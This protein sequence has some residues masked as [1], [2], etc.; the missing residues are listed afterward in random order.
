MIASSGEPRLLD[1]QTLQRALLF[2]AASWGEGQP[3]FPFQ[4]TT[5]VAEYVRDNLCWSVRESSSLLSNLLRLNF[6]GLCL[7]FD[8]IVAM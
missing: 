1:L 8:H 2:R 4:N 7:E 3:L 5:H 6:E